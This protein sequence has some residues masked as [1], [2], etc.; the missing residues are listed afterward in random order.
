M[1]IIDTA[2]P[3]W[4]NTDTT[5]NT[6]NVIIDVCGI[7]PYTSVARQLAACLGWYQTTHQLAGFLLPAATEAT[8]SDEYRIYRRFSNGKKQ[9][10]F[11]AKYSPYENMVAGVLEHLKVA[12]SRQVHI[13][14]WRVDFVLVGLDVIIEVDEPDGHSLWQD[15][16]EDAEQDRIT[17]LL[18]FSTIRIPTQDLEN[19]YAGVMDYLTREVAKAKRRPGSIIV[20]VKR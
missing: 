19:N 3:F 4:Y 11:N 13:D 15:R 12:Y 10:R 9:K 2:Q 1:R 14:R 5:L 20:Q 6:L 18:G 8:M 16:K 7:L 17:T